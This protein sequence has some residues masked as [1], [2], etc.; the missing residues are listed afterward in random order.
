MPQSPEQLSGQEPKKISRRDFLLMGGGA[1]AGVA[2]TT[3]GLHWLWKEN[4]E[5][6]QLLAQIEAEFKIKLPEFLQG[7]EVTNIKS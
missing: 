1:A 3:A 4:K 5:F 7:G 6:D 2:A